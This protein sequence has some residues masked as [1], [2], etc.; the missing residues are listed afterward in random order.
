MARTCETCEASIDHKRSDAR[1]CDRACKTKASDARRIKDGR[2]VERDQARYEREADHRRAY[3]RQYLKDNPERMRAIRRKR[4][5]QIRASH[6]LVL[7]RDWRRL[8]HRYRGMCA[9]CQARPWAH[10][11]H[12]IPLKRGGSHSIGNLLP[13]CAPCNL[14]KK[15]KLLAI[16]RYR[17]GAARAL[18]NG[19]GVIPTP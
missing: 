4:K 14:R 19:E 10:R 12:V 11:D 9:Y 17:D 7:E 13:A 16:W 18:S 15:I 8:V 1:F 2:S 5:G 6:S 3:A